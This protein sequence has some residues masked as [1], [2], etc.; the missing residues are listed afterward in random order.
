MSLGI[1]P[2]LLPLLYFAPE[3]IATGLVDEAWCFP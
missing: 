3:S 1:D 2:W